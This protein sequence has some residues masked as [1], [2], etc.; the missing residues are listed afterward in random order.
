M[1]S[2][3]TNRALAKGSLKLSG[4]LP[5]QH[6]NLALRLIDTCTLYITV[7][8]GLGPKTLLEALQGS[9][10]AAAAAETAG[11]LQLVQAALP[12]LSRPWHSLLS[13]AV[14]HQAAAYEVWAVWRCAGSNGQQQRQQQRQQE[15]VYTALDGREGATAASAA[16]LRVYNSNSGLLAVGGPSRAGSAASSRDAPAAEVSDGN[17][18]NGL[19]GVLAVVPLCSSSGQDVVWL[20]G[21][22]VSGPVR[23]GVAASSLQATLPAACCAGGSLQAAARTAVQSTSCAQQTLPAGVCVAFLASCCNCRSLCLC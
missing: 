5:G 10:L 4:L 20:Q 15:P 12:L 11:R 13:D 18:L 16:M 6:Y 14:Q 19:G 1:L 2:S 7:V 23:I 9:G 22:Q 8:L 17:N 3:S 21:H